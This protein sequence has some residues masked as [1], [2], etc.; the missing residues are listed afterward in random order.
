MPHV[1]QSAPERLAE[2]HSQWLHQPAAIGGGSTRLAALVRQRCP[3]CRHGAVFAGLFRMHARCAAC[4]LVF[5]RE[6]G[7]FTGAMYLSYGLG[8]LATAPVWLPMAL[9]G[10]PLG[11]VLPVVGGLLIA[12]SPWLF[13]Y[14]RV[15]WLHLDHAIDHW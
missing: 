12:G 3:R 10:R 9:L 6:Q 8:L 5:A 14:A 13:R 1:C 2:E 11:E 4:G 15:L 7:Y